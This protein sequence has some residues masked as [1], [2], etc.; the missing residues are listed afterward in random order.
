MHVARSGDRGSAPSTCNSSSRGAPLLASMGTFMHV[1]HIHTHRCTHLKNLYKITG[2]KKIPIFIRNGDSERHSTCFLWQMGTQRSKPKKV[3]SQS[4]HSAWGSHVISPPASQALDLIF[5]HLSSLF[6][7]SANLPLPQGL[8]T[9][10]PSALKP[11]SPH[12]LFS[13]LLVS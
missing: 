9:G 12:I 11:S 10:F 6:S 5:S 8:C 1:V 4:S 2:H 7:N 3:G 13:Y